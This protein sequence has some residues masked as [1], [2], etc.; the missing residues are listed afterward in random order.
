MN[1]ENC[2]KIFSKA[3]KTNED[4]EIGKC[5]VCRLKN[6]FFLR[7]NIEEADSFECT[8]KF[9]KHLD[10]YWEMSNRRLSPKLVEELLKL[11]STNIISTNKSAFLSKKRRRKLI[12]KPQHVTNA[13]LLMFPK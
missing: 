4:K 9:A 12:K 10:F 1:S 5:N 3:K 6:T 13:L 7:P 11:N 8:G 2:N